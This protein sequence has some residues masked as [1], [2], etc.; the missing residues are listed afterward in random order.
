VRPQPH[1]GV[2]FRDRRPMLTLLSSFGADKGEVI[3]RMLLG[4][5]PKSGR[6]CGWLGGRFPFGYGG[7]RFY[8]RW[9]GID[10]RTS[11]KDI[12]GRFQGTVSVLR[13]FDRRSW[14]PRPLTLRKGGNYTR[15]RER[16]ENEYA[17]SE[18]GSGGQE[19]R[20]AGGSSGPDSDRGDQATGNPELMLKGNPH[21][22]LR[23]RAKE[24][25][26]SSAQNE[27]IPR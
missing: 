7:T 16:I 8:T 23:V 3:R 9:R 10:S 18:S 24:V 1:R 13:Q 27:R 2:R 11:G 20:G 15:L 4:W 25:A 12:C 6:Q 5:R 19:S 17:K 26:K 14:Y 21:M 22:D